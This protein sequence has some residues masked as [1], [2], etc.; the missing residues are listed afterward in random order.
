M[1]SHDQLGFESKGVETSSRPLTQ[2]PGRPPDGV[3]FGSQPFSS[4]SG[5]QAP[6]DITTIK[7]DINH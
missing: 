4:L 1:I 5:W 6:D 2:N 3:P 7:Y